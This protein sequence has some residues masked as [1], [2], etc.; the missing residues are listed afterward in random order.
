MLGAS[1]TLKASLQHC[2]APPQV[3]TTVPGALLLG[4][5]P[6]WPRVCSSMQGGP[7][8]QQSLS[9]IGQEQATHQ[10]R[11]PGLAAGFCKHVCQWG[12]SSRD[13]Q[14][15]LTRWPFSPGIPARPSKPRSPC[16]KREDGSEPILKT[17]TL[18][19]TWAQLPT[20]QPNTN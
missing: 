13:C 4:S 11:V 10:E 2:T 16:W 3:A 5:G 12:T 1:S 18:A 20:P 6:L 9:P 17:S 8:G 14:G 15:S 7:G 19:H